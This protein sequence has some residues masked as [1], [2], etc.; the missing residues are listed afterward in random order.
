MSARRWVSIATGLTVVGLGAVFI[1][2]GLED[3]DQLASTVGAMTTVIGLGVTLYLSLAKTPSHRAGSSDLLDSAIPQQT[4]DTGYTAVPNDDDLDPSSQRQTILVIDRPQGIQIGDRNRQTNYYLQSPDEVRAA[5]ARSLALRLR[6]QWEAELQIRGVEQRLDVQLTGYL[7]S[8]DGSVS[9]ARTESLA[10]WTAAL[11]QAPRRR[12]V[13]SGRPGSGKST[14]AALTMLALLP[15]VKRTENTDKAPTGPV[16]VLLNASGWNPDKQQLDVWIAAQLAID[17]PALTRQGPLRKLAGW[18]QVPMAEQL[19]AQEL[20]LPVIDGLNELPAETWP[21]VQRELRKALDNAKREFVLVCGSDALPSIVPPELPDTLS[22][23]IEPVSTPDAMAYLGAG[24]PTA[25]RW[26]AVA[27]R[28]HAEPD[29]PAARALSTPLML[30]LARIVYGAPDTDPAELLDPDR[31]PDPSAVEEDL[32]ARYLGAVY[33][34]RPP[35]PAWDA[36]PA[37][38]APE[39][40]EEWAR[41]WLG[42]LARRLDKAHKTSFAWWELNSP[43]L[44]SGDPPRRLR[45]QLPAPTRIHGLGAA[46]TVVTYAVSSAFL[47][48]MGWVFGHGWARAI[49][50]LLAQVPPEIA[51]DPRWAELVRLNEPV[52][53]W[54]AVGFGSWWVRGLVTMAVLVVPIAA[55]FA[56][57]APDSDPGTPVSPAEE[58]RADRRLARVRAAGVAVLSLAAIPG[59]VAA[60]HP[61][62]VGWLAERYP[63]VGE[64]LPPWWLSG[65]LL[66]GLV[67]L[68]AAIAVLWFSAWGG[69]RVYT[70]GR[71][72]LLRLPRRTL[73]FLDDAHRRG[74]LRR[75]G[76]RYEFRHLLLQR[77]LATGGHPTTVAA[78]LNRARQL[79]AAGRQR[80]AAKLLRKVWLYSDEAP[81]LLA[82]VYDA[83]AAAAARWPVWFMPVWLRRVEEAV[84]WWRRAARQGDPAAEAGLDALYRR[85]VLHDHGWGTAGR[86]K[87]LVYHRREVARL[88]PEAD[89]LLA[90]MTEQ[91]YRGGDSLIDRYLRRDA[92]DRAAR[93]LRP[94]AR[95]DRPSR[96]VL[97]RLL[98]RGGRSAEARLWALLAT[99]G[100]AALPDP[101]GFAEPGS[102]RERYGRR[103][104][105]R[106]TRWA[107]QHDEADRI[108]GAALV[109]PDGHALEVSA[110]V[111]L[112]GTVHAAVDAAVAACP[113]GRPLSTGALLDAL[114]RHDPLGAWERVWEHTGDPGW[115]GLASAADSD[116]TIIVPG[117]VGITTHPL[118]ADLALSLRVLHRLVHHFGIRPAQPGA[119]ALALVADPG[120][121][122][123]RALLR[124]G[125]VSHAT[126]LDLITRELLHADLPDVSRIVNEVA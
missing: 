92:A 126:L 63:T 52:T 43:L 71:V 86:I 120:S 57:E 90:L 113:A 34:R 18:S 117:P 31:F 10:W 79:H 118:T 81:R 39:I 7:P 56:M 94:R 59:A 66:G 110:G 74:V 65:L 30:G 111:I 14:V 55:W 19:V 88:R 40:G 123:A 1:L 50:W 95:T 103:L 25:Q 99:G 21:Q 68:S 24:Q 93:I 89:R 98:T 54:L 46:L 112:S 119:L 100:P 107:G 47:A 2:I 67:A 80:A 12:M 91:A 26:E 101:L 73:E 87:C 44:S 35:Q 72:M 36:S 13:I 15:Q 38:T 3:A 62:L 109:G 108:K 53:G 124:H 85:E 96:R 69:F 114:A 4:T 97:I 22:V 48:G 45:T 16:P 6:R 84:L 29:S 82:E 77:H 8:R 70:A 64:Q 115:T 5:A 125:A 116:E 102:R 105:V 121:G 27:A 60:A 33:R 76:T 28:L 9:G 51:T 106:L 61:R 11:E 49:P 78:T 83:H 17:H 23:E 104:M 37:L 58:L 75:N 32:L 122:A 20:V 42:Y 41:R